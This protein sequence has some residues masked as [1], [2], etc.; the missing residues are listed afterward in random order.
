MASS[1]DGE[2]KQKGMAPL[3]QAWVT[4]P[5]TSQSLL[6]LPIAR[7]FNIIPAADPPLCSRRSRANSLGNVGS[8]V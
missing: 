7:V 1:T 5:V 3:T 4:H 6:R 8:S 2:E